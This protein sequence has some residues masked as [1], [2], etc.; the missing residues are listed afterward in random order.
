MAIHRP[1]AVLLRNVPLP[2][3][4]ARA[5]GGG[6]K[7]LDAQIP[8]VPFIDFLIVLVVFLLS[9]FDASGELPVAMALPEAE[10]ASA[11]DIAPV[12]AIDARSVTL[13]GRRVADTASLTERSERVRIEPLVDDLET[14]RANWRVL[15][16]NEPF[17]AAVV[18]SADRSIDYRVIQH[19]MF[20][21][22]QA[23]YGNIRLAVSER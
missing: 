12:I 22:A 20:T 18:L 17:P 11:L 9:S 5:A 4:R 2:F 10:H 14:L 23:G 21:A 13:D 16:P 7:A 3:V 6:R 8:L 15:H 19:V 1:G